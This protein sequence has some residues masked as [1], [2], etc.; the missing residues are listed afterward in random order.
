MAAL[1]EPIRLRTECGQGLPLGSLTSLACY[2]MGKSASRPGFWM[3]R[4]GRFSFGGSW[5]GKKTPSEE[6]DMPTPRVP[7]IKRLRMQQCGTPDSSYPSIRPWLVAGGI[8]REGAEL[9]T[10][11]QSAC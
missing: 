6:K 7:P 8:C 3:L 2:Q 11:S 10:P 5:Q 9:A 1:S 4:E